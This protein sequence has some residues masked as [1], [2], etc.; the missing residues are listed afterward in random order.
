VDVGA[1]LHGLGLERYEQA[2]RDNDVDADVLPELTADD[3][4]G[5]GITSVGHRRKLLAAIAALRGGPAPPA[6]PSPG[7]PAPDARPAAPP[8]EAERRQL[9]VMFV[10]L[11]GSTELSRRFDPEEM[12]ELIRTYQNLVAGEVT[13]F[14]GHVAKYMGD[15]VLAYFGWPRAHEDAAERAVRA[16]LAVA[17]AVPGIATPA[18]E[19]LAVRVGIATGPVVVG[20]LIGSGEARERAVVGETPNLAARLQAL[21]EPGAVVVA[22]GTRRLLGGLFALRDL[23]ARTLKGFAEPVR[24]FTVVGEGAAEGRFEALHASGLTPLV[25]REQELALLLDRWERAKEGEG[26]VVLLSGEA[27]IGKSRLVH[28]LRERLAA[29]PHTLLGQFCSPHHANTA[30]HPI[31][32]LLERAAGLRRE[33]PP[34]SQLDRLEAMLA[35]A[36]DDAGEATP[37]LADLLGIPVGDRYPPLDLSPRQRKERTFRALLDQLSGLAAK[38]PVLALYEDVHWADPTTLELIG[39]VIEQVQRVPVLVLV[40]FRPGFVQPWGGHGHVTALSLGRL[41]RRQ[42]EAMVGRVAGGK[43][44][45]AEVLDRILA[46]TDGVPLFVE[47]LTK[48]VLEAGLLTD[49]GDRYELRAP[50]PPLAIP[51]TLQDSLMARLDRLAPVKEVAQ[52]AAVIGREFSHELLAAVA[53]LHGTELSKGL[54]RLVA[55]ELVFRRGEAPKA[56]YVFKHALVRD[57]AYHSLLRSRRKELHGRIAAALEE[58]FP[59]TA[60]GQPELLA[61]H[62]AE[63]GQAERAILHLQ[64]AARRALARSADLEAAEHLRAALRQLDRVGGTERREVTEFEL[65]AALGRALSTVRGFA[66]PETDRA[67]ARAAE[68]GR[69]LQVGARLFPVLWGRYVAL[70]IAGQL[71]AGHRT[72]RE[73]VRLAR[74]SGD[75]GHRLTGERI[76][77]DSAW[78]F[79]RLASARRHLERALALYDPGAHRALALDY[80]YDQRAVVRDMLICTLFVL[81]YPEQADAQVR[82]AMVEVE[83]LRHRASLAHVLSYACFLDQLRGDAAGVLGHAAVVRRLAEEQAIPFWAG[84]AAVLEGW[85]LGREG[86]PEAGVAAILRALD[87]LLSIG[88]RLFRPYHLALL[89]DME[90]RA[91]LYDAASARVDE[92]LREVEDTGERWYEAELHRLRGELALRQGCDASAA[93]PVFRTALRIARRQAARTWELRAA[94]S[95]ARLWAGEGDRQRAVDL[96]SPVYASFTEG[97][98]RPDLRD[99]RALLDALG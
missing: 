50:L 6:A 62:L 45:P 33:K 73:F 74:R 78:A 51:S 54:D 61:H 24:A 86:S 99:A 37:V 34:G 2:F 82:Q 96:L 31:I 36:V 58:R 97:F 38:G 94:V 4:T 81:G 59:E 64:R 5:L 71:L 90:G 93:E 16:G 8:S 67:F 98:D 32:G 79:G 19:R 23:G 39:R 65:Q 41:R 47:E 29:E 42:G 72:A 60:E 55:A 95:L 30:L 48:A 17:A 15:G 91:G 66:A 46:R 11:A 22:E 18:G 1:W 27:G 43:V 92:A 44:L 63:A 13:R 40:T 88:V 84:R 7:E 85:A 25:G 14:D 20:E 70:H 57:A 26:Q 80:A 77:G 76:L 69:R 49:K 53:P 87:A 10:D 83:A 89:A 21:A 35:L 68:L 28:A 56:G 3:L 75:T 12:R 52:V 9:T